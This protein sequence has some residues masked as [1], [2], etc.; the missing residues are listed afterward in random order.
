MADIAL[1]R[2]KSVGRIANPSYPTS[3]A[4]PIPVLPFAR[5][6]A[7]IRIRCPGCEKI[8]SVSE[9][10]A[11]L[12]ATCPACDQLFRIPTP[13]PQKRTEPDADSP[14]DE[15]ARRSPVKQSVAQPKG[16]AAPR[17][18][19]AGEPDEP[20]FRM[21]SEPQAPAGSKKRAP[22]EDE[23]EDEPPAAVKKPVKRRKKLKRKKRKPSDEIT[24]TQVLVTVTGAMLFIWA[25]VTALLY[26][27]PKSSFIIF[28]LARV[29]CGLSVIGVRYVAR[30]EGLGKWFMVVFIP[31]Y[32]IYFAIRYPKEAAGVVVAQ[33]FFVL[34]LAT[35]WF[36]S[37]RKDLAPAP[38]APRQV[39][40]VAPDDARLGPMRDLFLLPPGCSQLN[41]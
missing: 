1:V 2:N 38:A 24:T 3:Q 25:G 13:R 15:K 10:K 31:F 12:V 6:K 39:P 29:A 28:L 21:Q 7:M 8:L 17:D 11:G 18:G 23:E 26:F 33:Y 34:I 19:H 30:Q 32:D 4:D 35:V 36:I 41:A 37:I 5:K 27:V 14:A 40:Q 20:P 9:A 16:E 22:A